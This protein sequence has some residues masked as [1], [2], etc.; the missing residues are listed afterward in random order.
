MP[1]RTI[2]K[3]AAFVILAA[4]GVFGT[5]GCS[6]LSPGGQAQTPP[7]EERAPYNEPKVVGKLE[8]EEIKESSGLTASKCQPDVFWTHNDSGDEALVYAMDSKG[9]HR[10]TWKVTGAENDDWEDIASHKD[11]SG[12][13]FLYIGEIGNNARTRAAQSVYRVAEPVI[14][15]DDASSSRKNSKATVQSEKLSFNFPDSPHDAETLMV[16]PATGDI[17]VVS[18]VLTG[19]AG[20]YKI[21]PQ[22][23]SGDVQKAEKIGDL[24]VPAVPNG[25]LTSGDISP[26]GKRVVVCD[27]FAAYELALPA[28]TKNFDDVWKQKPLKF[29]TGKREIGEAI[30]YAADGDS[31]FLTSEKKRSPVIEIK[32]RP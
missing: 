23:G 29:E 4:A 27:Y 9:G 5:T 11:S 22:F 10:G 17:Y 13:C 24:S 8:S 21:K 7:T 3:F 14:A 16:H 1:N 15:E 20:V 32:R 18:K 26:D 6:L 19:P 31:V 30:A 28:G 12:K 25:L 2:N